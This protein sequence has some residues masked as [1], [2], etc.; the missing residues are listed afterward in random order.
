M[1][2]TL[3]GRIVESL[4]TSSRL[5]NAEI[6]PRRNWTA[7]I[8]R[9]WLAALAV[10]IRHMLV[11]RSSKQDPGVPAPAQAPLLGRK[12]ARRRG[13]PVVPRA[14]TILRPGQTEMA[15]ARVAGTAAVGAEPSPRLALGSVYPSTRPVLHTGL[16][17][18]S[19]VLSGSVSS[20][21]LP[22]AGIG[23]GVG[24]VAGVET[25]VDAGVA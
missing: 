4:R 23:V 25:G 13:T 11:M 15:G 1:G 6:P 9:V 22:P 21:K 12:S 24:V 19:L 3:A 2:P 5:P 10:G 16:R 7:R 14:N 20:G 18:I 17:W 8:A